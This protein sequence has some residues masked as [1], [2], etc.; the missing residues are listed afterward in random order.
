[1]FHTGSAPGIPPS[2]HFPPERYPGCYHPDAPTYRSACRCSRHPKVMGRPKQAPVPGFLP[3]RESLAADKG[4]VHRPLDAPLGFP[5]P[6][7]S[8]D[9][10][11]RAF[12][13]T[14]LTRF[15]PERLPAR[16]PASQSIDRLPLGLVSPL[17]HAAT[18]DKATLLGFLHRANPDT[19]ER[20]PDRAMC[21]PPAAPHI[22]AGRPAIFGQ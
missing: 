9:S 15:A 8:G 20:A 19:F 7:Y 10:L 22:A 4:L 11:T 5:L 1:L 2:E 3:S 18:T 12:T 17:P 14:P 6:G 16:A 13:R 21:S